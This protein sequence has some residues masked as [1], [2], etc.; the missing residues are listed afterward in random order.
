MTLGRQFAI[1]PFAARRPPLGFLPWPLPKSPKNPVAMNPILAPRPLRTQGFLVTAAAALGALC[2]TAQTAPEK[3]KEEILVMSPFTVQTS[4][5]IGYEASRTLAGMGLNTKLT[6]LG[7]AVSVVTPTQGGV[8]GEPSLSN[9]Q[10]GARVRG[11]ADATMARN[12]YRSIIPMDSYNTDRVEMNRGASALLFG[13][14]SPAGIVNTSTRSADLQRPRG[15]VELTG[16]SY[17]TWR[18]TLDCNVVPSCGNPAVR[19][20]GVKDAEKYQQDF[21][22]TDTERKYAAATWDVKPLRNRGILEST[23][24]SASYERGRIVSN[25]PRVLPPSDRLSSWFEETIPANLKALGA[26]GKVTYDRGRISRGPASCVGS[27]RPFRRLQRFR[28]GHPQC[29][30][31]RPLRVDRQISTKAVRPACQAPNSSPSRGSVAKRAWI[32]D[33]FEKF[34]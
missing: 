6:D 22:Y 11:L 18:A 30:R 33:G 8:T 16:G 25:N 21:A 31:G 13:V 3:P 20:A 7:A 4:K 23:V 14:G 9:A 15:E 5:D 10:T 28:R 17:G 19:V 24:V 12:F 32:F 27:H 29:L 2:L 1:R 34:Q 26:R